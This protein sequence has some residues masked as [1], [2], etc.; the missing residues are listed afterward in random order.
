MKKR[1]PLYNKMVWF[2]FVFSQFSVVAFGDRVELFM[3]ANI[4]FMLMMATMGIYL[5][6]T[7]LIINKKCFIMCPFLLFS[8]ASYLWSQDAS[9][10]FVRA[11]TVLKLTI[12]FIIL[13]AYISKTGEIQE[14]I[15]G[16]GISGGMIFL[17]TIATYGISGL[18][19]QLESGERVGGDIANQ[20]TL[21]ISLAFSM[22]ICL[23]FFLKQKKWWLLIPILAFGIVVALTG[24]KK[25]IIDIVVG[26]ILVVLFSQNDKNGVKKVLKVL[27]ELTIFSI[28]FA[29]LWQTPLFEII[30]SRTENLLGFISG[31]EI[32]YSTKVRAAMNTIG[33]NQ[34]LKTPIVGIGIGASGFLTRQVLGYT[35]YLH[36][37]YIELLAT[38]GIIGTLLFYIPV[39]YMFV[40]NWK[41]SKESEQSRIFVI[42]LILIFINDYASVGYFSRTN[43]SIYSLALANFVYENK[44]QK[45]QRG[46]EN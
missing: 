14:Y 13:V 16:V 37:N 36:N 34:F 22:V 9:A 26:V 4:S 45:Y 3:L 29:F 39:L 5:I 11:T 33:I 46:I 17:Y 44:N 12:M 24:S 30:R 42:L 38:G 19:Q 32:D 35:T 8:F 21:A 2:I 10:T 23:W 28:I 27:L 40:G 7:G 15:I 6:Y 18:R 31:V 43:I 25:G 20:N 1:K 41:Y